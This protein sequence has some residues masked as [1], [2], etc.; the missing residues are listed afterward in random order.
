MKSSNIRGFVTLK[1][2]MPMPAPAAVREAMNAT[3]MA[4][5][6]GEV[7]RIIN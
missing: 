3:S 1:N 2:R 7:E 5:C 4:S 6:L